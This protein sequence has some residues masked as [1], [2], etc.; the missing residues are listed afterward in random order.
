M[1]HVKVSLATWALGLRDKRV[2][3]QAAFWAEPECAHHRRFLTRWA[4][5]IVM[6]G[7]G[8][9]LFEHFGVLPGA[10]TIRGNEKGHNSGPDGAQINS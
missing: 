4:G 2:E 6:P 10:P 7:S 3:A 5:K 8:F 9:Q 1:G